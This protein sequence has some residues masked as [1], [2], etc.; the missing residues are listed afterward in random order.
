MLVLAMQFSRDSTRPEASGGAWTVDVAP[1][2]SSTA[3][4]EVTHALPGG[5]PKHAGRIGRRAGRTL[6]TEQ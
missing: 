1:E 5:T 3:T 4:R 6:T 2:Q